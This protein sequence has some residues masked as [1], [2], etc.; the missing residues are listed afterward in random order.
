MRFWSWTPRSLKS[1]GPGWEGLAT[2]Y[3]HATVELVQLVGQAQV[4]NGVGGWRVVLC[5]L[6]E[7]F[8]DRSRFLKWEMVL[9]FLS[10]RVYSRIVP[11]MNSRKME[12]NPLELF[13]WC[14]W[15]LLWWKSSEYRSRKLSYSFNQHIDWRLILSQLLAI[16]LKVQ[17]LYKFSFEAWKDLWQRG[18]NRVLKNKRVEQELFFKQIYFVARHL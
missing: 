11:R 15:A 10:V 8:P 12:I 13:P 16:C 5:D 3:L 7:H 1:P 14:S 4:V 9:E 17:S 2:S 18:L 6:S